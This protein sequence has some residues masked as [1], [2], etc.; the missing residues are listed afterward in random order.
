M[1]SIFFAISLV[2]IIY[3]GVNILKKEKEHFYM[4][5]RPFMLNI[6][7]NLILVNVSVVNKSIVLLY[8]VVVLWMINNRFAFI[9]KGGV[10]K[11]E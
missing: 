8:L 11:H 2:F 4:F 1:N 10:N 6:L 7:A 5:Y 9:G 3:D